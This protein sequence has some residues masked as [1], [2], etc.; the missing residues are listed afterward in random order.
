MTELDPDVLALMR[1]PVTRTALHYGSPALLDALNQAI[2]NRT[3]TNRIGQTISGEI[4]GVLV[5]ETGEI[6]LAIR[7]QIVQ[8]IAEESI[9]IPE[10]LRS[11]TPAQE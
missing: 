9:A 8:L 6:G 7:S 3:L 11:I 2:G 4:D 5:N 1:C 10:S